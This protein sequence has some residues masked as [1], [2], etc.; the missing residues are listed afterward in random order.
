MQ[1][2]IIPETECPIAFY[3]ARVYVGQSLTEMGISFKLFPMGGKLK[4]KLLEAKKNYQVVFIVNR[5]N[6]VFET[7]GAFTNENPKMVTI[8]LKEAVRQILIQS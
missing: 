5:K 3:Y 4:D 1:V 2:A 8:P 6:S 7:V